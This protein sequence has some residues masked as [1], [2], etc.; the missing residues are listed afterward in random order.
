MVPPSGV[1]HDFGY[2]CKLKKVLYGLKQAPCGW[3]EKFFVVIFSLGFVSNSHYSTLF[4]KCTDT[5]CIIMS[6]YIDDMIITS[7]DIDGILVL[8]TELIRQFKM[9]DL[10]SLR[11]FLGI[12]V[13]Y[14][15]KSYLI[16]QSKYVTNIF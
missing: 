14:S 1:S 5:G 10:C 7:D 2:I 9:K 13:A 8:K 16:S 15:Y 11:Y 4:I 3:F 6:L 12:V